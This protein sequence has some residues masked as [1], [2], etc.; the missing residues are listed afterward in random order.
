MRAKLSSARKFLLHTE[1]VFRPRCRFR[2]RILRPL[3]VFMRMRKPW[4]LL[5]RILL[6]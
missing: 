1:S 3:L 5:R 2:L 4:V 6:G